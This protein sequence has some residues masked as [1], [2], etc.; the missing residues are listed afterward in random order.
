MHT[1][2]QTMVDVLII[3]MASILILFALGLIVLHIITT[4]NSKRV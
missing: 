3:V 1:W 2:I 4:S